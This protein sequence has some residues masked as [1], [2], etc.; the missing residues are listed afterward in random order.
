MLIII[1][2]LIKIIFLKSSNCIKVAQKF[3][4]IFRIKNVITTK[5]YRKK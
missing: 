2:S 3:K 1:N 4:K 5:K